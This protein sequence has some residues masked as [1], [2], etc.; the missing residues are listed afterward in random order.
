[1]R[2]FISRLLVIILPLS[3]SYSQSTIAIIPLEAKGVSAIEASVLTDRLAL[4][5]FATGKYRVLE[6]GNM[7]AILAEQ[8]FQLSG[9]VSEECV[10]EV[11]SLLGVESI[12]AGSVSKFGATFTIGL[13]LINVESGELVRVASYD[14]SGL[15]DQLLS[16]GIPSVARRLSGQEVAPIIGSPAVNPS[17]QAANSGQGP[18]TW[19]INVG[20][21]SSQNAN[22]IGV[23]KDIFAGRHF[24]FYITGGLGFETIG[25]GIAY[26]QRYNKKGVVLSTSLGVILDEG[27]I[28]TSSIAYQWPLGRRGFLVTGAAYVS[29]GYRLDLVYP[30]LSYEYRF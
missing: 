6:R 7:E 10:V 12:V 27:P 20:L 29:D 3:F 26:Q 4:E 22:I 16:V 24:S 11:G 8:N 21:G 13:R 9:C 17:E 23:S 14:H 30:V 2:S 28:L 19:S 5:L 15:I 1:M 25:M 18:R